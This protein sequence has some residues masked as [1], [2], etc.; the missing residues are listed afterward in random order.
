MDEK[1]RAGAQPFLQ[2][3]EDVQQVFQAIGGP[4]GPWWRRP[5]I[6]PNTY[7]DIP[8][9]KREYRVV[10]VTDRNIVLLQAGGLRQEKV[11]GLVAR[12][13]LEPLASS[14]TRLGWGT[15]PIGGNRYFVPRHYVKMWQSAAS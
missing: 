1:L 15:V 7:L 13:P 4:K 3:D 5:I 6:I 9:E 10:A 11:T 12:L 2:P 8:S 14:K